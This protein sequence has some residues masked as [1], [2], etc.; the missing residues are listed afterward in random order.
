MWI[1]WHS[2]CKTN[3]VVPVMAWFESP[4]T[5]CHCSSFHWEV[6]SYIST[7]LNMALCLISTNEWGRDNAVQLLS[8]LRD[9][10]LSC[11]VGIPYEEAQRDLVSL[12]MKD[13]W[14]EA[15]TFQLLQL[16]LLQPILSW[17]KSTGKNSIE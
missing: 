8:W 2:C 3:V 4:S 6:A 17:I 14:S 7:P 1:Y 15:Q 16:N 9:C 10:T 5:M 12:R 13:I 11:N